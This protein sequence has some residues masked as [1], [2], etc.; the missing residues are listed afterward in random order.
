MHCSSVCGCSW[1]QLAAGAAGRQWGLQVSRA[2]QHCRSFLAPRATHPPV[3]ALPP[4]SCFLAVRRSGGRKRKAAAGSSLG[5]YLSP[6]MQD[7]LGEER[8][9]RTQVGWM[10]LDHWLV[11]SSVLHRWGRT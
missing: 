7:F 10:L 6:D 8:L 4:P 3:P 9:P 11:L 5:S 2:S 1:R